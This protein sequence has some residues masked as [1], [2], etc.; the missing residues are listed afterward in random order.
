MLDRRA[1]WQHNKGGQARPRGT[2]TGANRSRRL[3][4]RLCAGKQPFALGYL[5]QAGQKTCVTGQP[6]DVSGPNVLAVLRTAR[7]AR[8]GCR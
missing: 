7:R 2:E 4:H 8:R 3:N 1:A 5:L 6:D